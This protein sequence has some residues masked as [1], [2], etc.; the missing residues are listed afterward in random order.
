MGVYTREGVKEE[1]DKREKDKF[2]GLEKA[3][4]QGDLVRPR[5]TIFGVD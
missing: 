3:F 1:A 4:N 2:E 5:G